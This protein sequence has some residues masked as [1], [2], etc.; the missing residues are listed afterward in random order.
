MRVIEHNPDSGFRPCFT[1]LPYPFTAF[2]H[3]RGPR[4]SRPPLRTSIPSSA[5]LCVSPPPWFQ[6]SLG[7]TNDHLS[8]NIPPPST[9]KR[10]N[11]S[12]AVQQRLLTPKTFGAG[13][14]FTLY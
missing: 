7:S 6:A 3:L 4:P 12:E 2:F 5:W 10:S 13:S 8:K 11:R 9:G 1:V 14:I